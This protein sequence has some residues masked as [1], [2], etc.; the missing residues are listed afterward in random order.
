MSVSS[1]ARSA[2]LLGTALISTNADSIS[3][4]IRAGSWARLAV[5]RVRVGGRGRP[6]RSRSGG[7]W[8]QQR[9]RIEPGPRF[10]GAELTMGGLQPVEALGELG[11]AVDVVGQHAR[12][13]QI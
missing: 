4:V 7:S 9:R 10:D 1:D 5:Q 6:G 2:T 8:P 3:G 13:L 11:H 12:G